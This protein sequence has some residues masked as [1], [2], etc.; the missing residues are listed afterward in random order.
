MQSQSFHHSTRNH[1]EIRGE[2]DRNQAS[3]TAFGLGRVRNVAL[4]TTNLLRITPSRQ[5]RPGKTE[6]QFGPRDVDVPRLGHPLGG[7]PNPPENLGYDP[8]SVSGNSSRLILSV[9]RHQNLGV[10]KAL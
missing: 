8:P 4:L 10:I 7:S 5:E 6:I 3:P 2:A 1:D 9:L